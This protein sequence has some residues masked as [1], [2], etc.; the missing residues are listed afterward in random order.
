MNTID[1]T[2]ST[3]D[4]AIN[5]M[6]L[7]PTDQII[8]SKDNFDPTFFDIST[9]KLGEFLQK[10]TNYRVKLAIIGDFTDVSKSFHDFI[11]ESNKRREYLFVNSEEEAEKLWSD[12]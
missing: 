10:F 11:Y 3:P 12:N 6:E 8:I 7:F 2:I 1:F 5:L 4:D 9:R